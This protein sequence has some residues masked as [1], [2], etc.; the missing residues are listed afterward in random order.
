ML[1]D[2]G[3]KKPLKTDYKIAG[4][5]AYTE[6]DEDLNINDSQLIYE[7]LEQRNLNSST[8]LTFR[9]FLAA[10]EGFF[11]YSILAQN[12]IEYIIR[13]NLFFSSNIAFKILAI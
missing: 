2:S 5:D 11:K 3:I 1:K 7:R 6:I 13:D 8:R 10:R 9:P 4:L 12:D